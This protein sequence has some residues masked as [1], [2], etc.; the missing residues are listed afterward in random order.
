MTDKAPL[1]AP[2]KARPAPPRW[3]RW[4]RD[5]AFFLVVFA[6]I[7]WWQSRDLVAGAAPPL[8]GHLVDGAPFQLDPARGPFL[9]HFWATWCPICR[10]EQDSIASIAA[11]RP[12]ITVATTSGDSGELA[13]YLAEHG[14]QMP[15]LMDEDGTIARAWG[16]SGV[17]STFV[18]DTA[19]R[20]RHA[21]TG[22]S[23]ELGLRLRLWWTE[24]R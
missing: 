17:P 16:V 13:D 4:T 14:L 9:V 5:I 23:T 8:L 19:G 3:L 24:F 21:G 18:I 10:L 20:I 2:D 1:R 7:Q 15:V 11:D 12:V 6:A 22:Y